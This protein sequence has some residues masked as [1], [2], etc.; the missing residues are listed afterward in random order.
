MKVVSILS[1][2]LPDFSSPLE[3]RNNTRMKGGCVGGPF[4]I[5]GDYSLVLSIRKVEL[6]GCVCFVFSKGL[7]SPTSLC[8]AHFLAPAGL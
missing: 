5:I 7:L 3:F 8:L 1:E 6:L 2:T 4:P